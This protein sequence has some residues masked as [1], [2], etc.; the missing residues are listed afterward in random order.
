MFSYT[1][2]KKYFEENMF[3]KVNFLRTKERYFLFLLKKKSFKTNKFLKQ[4]GRNK[5][6][7]NRVT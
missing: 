7:I 1:V 2:V 4:E 5:I 3:Q 6:K